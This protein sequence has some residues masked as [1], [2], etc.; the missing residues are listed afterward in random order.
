MEPLEPWYEHAF[1]GNNESDVPM[2]Y[3]AGMFS[4]DE[5]QLT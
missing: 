3:N 2:R 5:S 1:P 4:R